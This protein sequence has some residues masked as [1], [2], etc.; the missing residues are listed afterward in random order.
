MNAKFLDNP[1]LGPLSRADFITAYH[2]L[3]VTQ[4]QRFRTALISAGIPIEDAISEG[5]VW[6]IRAYDRYD[7]ADYDFAALAIPY[8]TGAIKKMLRRDGALVRIPHNLY[9]LIQRIER[10]GLAE[11]PPEVI[12]AELDVSIANVKRALTC[13]NLRTAVAMPERETIGRFDDYSADYTAAFLKRLKPKP[14]RVIRML[15]D[16]YTQTEVAKEIGMSR[17]AVQIIVKR[18]REN[19]ER[20]EKISA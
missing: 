5:T 1:L 18:V 13:I 16:E 14:K 19:Y 7:R 15:M 12:A 9:P 4:A 6:L 10:A 3:V 8:I 20:Y 2:P 17:Q 11:S